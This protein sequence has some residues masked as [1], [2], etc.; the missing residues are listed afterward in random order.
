MDVEV[1][2]ERVSPIVPGMAGRKRDK[3]EFKNVKNSRKEAELY[4]KANGKENFLNHSTV[5]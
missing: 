4:L 1:C 5:H 2:D 3:K